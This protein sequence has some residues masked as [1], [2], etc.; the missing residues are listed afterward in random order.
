VQLNARQA[1][2]AGLGTVLLAPLAGVV[3][4]RAPLFNNLV[5]RD[6]WFYSGYGWM[7]D[8]H[9][10]TFGW[11]YYAV[12]FPVILPIRWFTE[13]FGPV[14]G[15]LVLRYIILAA[16]GAVI[17]MCVRQFASIWV[18]GASVL[19]LA[20]NPF[21]IRMILW[22]YTSYVA[23]PCSIAGVALWLMASTRGRPLWIFIV[24][25]ALYGAAVFAN[26]LSA[27]VAVP[28][29]LVELV[30]ACRRG[31]RELGK[32]GLR[33]ASAALGILLVFIGGYLGYR[34]YLGAYAPKELIE[35]TWEFIRQ[36]DQLAAP[37]ERPAS[38]FLDGEP[39]IYA[40]VLLCL[41]M[42]IAMGS[43]ILEDTL[44]GRLAQYT[45]GYLALIWLYRLAVTSSVV[46]TWWA[47]NMTAVSMCFAVALTLDQLVRRGG[48]ESR[49]RVTLI[50][51]VGGAAIA[52]IA[53]RYS[54]TSAIDIYDRIRDNAVL[55]SIIVAAGVLAAATMRLLP[56]WHARAASATVFFAVAAFVALAPARYI[57][58]NQTGEF[59][60]DGRGDLYAYEGAYDMAK[61]LKKTD[62]PNSRTLVWTTSSGF[63]NMV[64]TNLPH[65]GGA[66]Q[67]PET[68]PATLDEIQPWE[69]S[70]VH[71][72]TTDAVLLISENP[73]D[74][75][76]GVA[77]LRRVHARPVVRQRG[78]W[79]H[80]NLQYALVD[81]TPP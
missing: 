33:C 25:G 27:T 10:E 39:R 60:A 59:V 46:E 64:W 9:V 4:L 73:A 42:V 26:P 63:A 61:L 67:S 22:D 57:G 76:R 5:Y 2:L 20:I 81:V 24:C 40:P 75:A 37:F 29:V 28:L 12:R 19:F 74:M 62:Q 56:V 1:R 54:N 41:A 69:A 49:A 48:S 15:Y 65:Q 71:Y 14:T 3:V 16:T 38:E 21:Y 8:H 45:V 79:A 70:L 47:Y 34:A 77:A 32:F 78:S 18:A 43:R 36:N 11:F 72:P 13:L 58:I 52:T 80:G 55:V 68:P 35:P 50:A 44:P 30:A 7:L 23:V 66:I 53:I 6:P 51:A 31:L 17:Y